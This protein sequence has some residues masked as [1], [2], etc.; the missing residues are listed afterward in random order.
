[1][2]YYRLVGI[3]TWGSS[4]L[5]LS[6]IQPQTYQNPAGTVQAITSSHA[7]I[8]GSLA[9]LIDA[10]LNTGATFAASDVAKP[11]FQIVLDYGVDSSSVMALGCLFGTMTTKDSFIR[12]V[13]IQ[14]SENGKVWTNLATYRGLTYPGPNLL[15][16]RASV[17]SLAWSPTDKGSAVTLSNSNRTA[18]PSGYLNSAVRAS[19]GFQ[20]G[21]Y[22]W[23]IRLGTVG[24]TNAPNFGVWP[25]SRAIS[26]YIYQTTGVRRAYQAAS[27][28]DVFGFVFNASA[29]TC[30]VRRNNVVVGSVQ[31]EPLPM[32]ELWHP[33][34]GD[35]NAGGCS[36]TLNV[37]SQDLVYSPPAGS[38]VVPA[39]SS[40]PVT[41]NATADVF[42]AHSS[43]NVNTYNVGDGMI[44]D[45]A[46]LN[47]PAQSPFYGRVVL[48]EQ[49]S[50][51]MVSETWTNP[52]TGAF[53][54]TYLNRRTKYFM[55]LF[56]PAGQYRGA[57]ATGVT[58]QPMTT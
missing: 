32:T 2:R 53:V 19:F 20:S 13:L 24:G 51:R 7:P 48:F 15:T 43:V 49:D 23:E 52:L 6:L 31:G 26:T 55:V 29:G 14:Q 38:S 1:M 28:N 17:G 57:F 42:V 5:S 10:D 21:T 22:Y 33:V 12:D 37:L 50:K 18:T 54:F 25:A 39:E 9:N 3:K 34:T 16:Q 47:N 36:F 11:G 45:Y 35:D 27:T 4:D 58:P 8:S 40:T 56:D 41:E 46:K 30:E 44:S